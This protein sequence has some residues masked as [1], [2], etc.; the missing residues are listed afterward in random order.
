M[1][2]YAWT[3]TSFDCYPVQDGH[4]NVAYQ[5]WYIYTATEDDVSGSVTGKNAISPYDGSRPFVPFP[6]L[7]PA[8]VADWL[9]TGMGPEAL[10]QLRARAD[11]ALHL[12]QHPTSVTLSPPWTP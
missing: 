2:T 3:F 12:V 7:T 8:I 5:V 11:A 1:P 10:A 4:A 9:E 6:D